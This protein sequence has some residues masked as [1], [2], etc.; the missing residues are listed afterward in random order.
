MIAQNADRAGESLTVLVSTIY[1]L[2][3]PK[4]VYVQLYGGNGPMPAPL[5]IK[6]DKIEKQDGNRYVVT[7][8]GN[9][10]GDFLPGTVA[11]WWIQDEESPKATF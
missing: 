4:Y 10:V 8:N 6:A 2:S 7:L 3:M 9:Q 11:G 5:K 1:A